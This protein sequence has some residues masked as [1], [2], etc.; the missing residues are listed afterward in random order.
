MTLLLKATAQM[1]E[2]LIAATTYVT[3]LWPVVNG[4][5]LTYLLFGNL[6]CKI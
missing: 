1:I 5:M 6:W 3:Y 2:V 4:V